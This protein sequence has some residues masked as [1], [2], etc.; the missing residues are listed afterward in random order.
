MKVDVVMEMLKK[1]RVIFMILII[2]GIAVRIY[3]FPNA[4]KEI[5]TDEIMTIANAKSIVDTGKELSGI[6][7]PVY[8]QGWGG[9]SVILLYLMVLS[10]KIFGLSLFAIRL[11][12]LLISIISLFVF[13]NLVKKIN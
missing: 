11:P 3:N 7:F 13:Y 10:I 5:N 1:K 4:L 8:L 9:Q 2:I 12:M 6:S